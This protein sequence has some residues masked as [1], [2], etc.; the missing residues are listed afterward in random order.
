M[1]PAFYFGIEQA[2]FYVAQSTSV[3]KYAF[4]GCF[5]RNRTDPLQIVERRDYL[6]FCMVKTRVHVLFT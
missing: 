4:Y 6:L 3:G 5:D 2:A 1:P